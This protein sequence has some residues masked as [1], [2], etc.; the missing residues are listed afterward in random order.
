[1]ARLNDLLRYARRSDRRRVSTTR[2]GSFQTFTMLVGAGAA[3]GFVRQL[4]RIMFGP[5]ALRLQSAE[6]LILALAALWLLGPLSVRPSIPTTSLQ[7]SPITDR[8]RL[9]YRVLSHGQNIE[10]LLML[11]ASLLGILALMRV[12]ESAL[13]M[14]QAATC[15]IAAASAGVALRFGFTKLTTIQ[16]QSKFPRTREQRSF[17]FPV[18]PLFRK[19]ISYFARTLDP[20]LGLIISFGFSYS[21]LLASWLTPA[22]AVVPLLLVAAVQLSAIVNPFAL[23]NAAEKDRYRLMPLPAWK[24]SVHKHVALTTIL[25]F[26]MSPLLVAALVRMTLMQD[27]ATFVELSIILLSWLCSGVI[28]MRLDESRNIRMSFGSLSGTGFSFGLFGLAV[29]ILVS[30]PLTSALLLR[31]GTS[32]LAVILSAGLLCALGGIYSVGLHSSSRTAPCLD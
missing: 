25:L 32:P 2:S 12:P 7:V 19:E 24:I 26:T 18:H 30:A 31:S 15:F 17:Q 11:I 22:K 14:A 13:Q 16:S 21:E 9:L 20:Y 29:L 5:V 8:Q 28:L 1:M 6:Y 3:F 27:L 10:T 4:K 23:D